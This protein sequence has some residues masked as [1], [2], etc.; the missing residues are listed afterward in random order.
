MLLIL[1]CRHSLFATMLLRR[2]PLAPLLLPNSLDRTRDSR[3]IKLHFCEKN[4]GN[5]QKLT[6]QWL[7]KL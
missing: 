1:V 7:G 6:E 3:C 5:G 4:N 2:M